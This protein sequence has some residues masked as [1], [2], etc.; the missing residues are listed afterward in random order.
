[1]KRSEEM[2]GIDS[3]IN[4]ARATFV[5]PLVLALVLLGAFLSAT[6]VNAQIAEDAL[7]EV[8]LTF[9]ASIPS[10]DF[11]D[12]FDTLGANTGFNIRGSGG[13][14]LLDNLSVGLYFNYSEF[15][16]DNPANPLKYRIYD[17]GGYAKLILS[18][19]KKLTPYVRG[20]LG[21]VKPNIATPI[22]SPQVGFREISYTNGIGGGGFLGLRFSTF[23]YGGLFAEVGYRAEF[24]SAKN[25][26]FANT[27]Y[28]LP[29]DI[30]NI[31]LNAGFNLDFGPK[32]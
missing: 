28:E 13:Y 30:N 22:T 26:S 19:E 29:A 10:S 17:F 16:V 20:E 9:G 23:E 31:Q 32:Q 6:N 5:A 3:R 4:S 8:N 27:T 14:Y 12:Y 18:P 24:V 2:I 25:G 15:E 21:L 11:S 7:F 1:M